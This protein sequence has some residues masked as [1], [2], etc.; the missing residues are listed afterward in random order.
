M[1][2]SDVLQVTKLPE[3]PTCEAELNDLLI[4]IRKNAT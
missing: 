4:R 3:L 1:K 2:T